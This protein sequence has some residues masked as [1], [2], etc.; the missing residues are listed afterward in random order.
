MVSKVVRWLRRHPV[1][2]G[3][4]LTVT[5]AGLIAAAV[6]ADLGRWPY[7]VGT[8]L[9]VVGLVLVVV[10]LLNRRTPAIAAAL[11]I[12]LGLGGGAWLALNTLPDSHPHW[13]EGSNEGHLAVDSFR[14]GSILFAEGIARDAQTGEVRW[15][16]PDD[17]HVMTT[18]D[19]TVVLD[20]AVEGEEGRR[21]V[22]RLIDSGR[23]VWW[24]MTRGR[25]TAV[26]Q[27]DGVLVISTREGTT[28][29]DLTTGDELW[30]SAR[31]AGTECKQGVPLTLDV[32]D[33]QQS[34]VFLPSSKRG[35]KGVDLAR[36][37]DGEVVA[38]GL[39]C[40]NYG[41]VVA[42]I[43]VEHGDGVLTGRSVSTGALEWEQDWIAQ[44]RPFSLPDSDGTIYIPDKLSRDG[45]GSTVD[46]YS[47][48]DLRTGEITQ[49]RPPGGWVSDTD[50][51]QD[52]RADVLWQPVRRGAS[53]GLWEVG[54]PKVVRIPGSPRISISEADSS[55]W[56]AVDGST[57]NIVGE[58][59][60][61][62][63]A[64]S[65]DGTL[66]G[67]FTGGSAPLDGASTIADGVL[68][69]GA[70]VYPLK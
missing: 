56:V 36:V 42:G 3:A 6:L 5:G 51:V 9:L 66:H 32:P 22:A 37:Y 17:S 13:E 30:T 41:R 27:H 33:L 69:V 49:T 47:A 38:R 59:T 54:T 31:R 39:D 52:Q 60:R 35:S 25:P 44:A 26:A 15:T 18:T 48:L 28:G 34:V 45:K 43:Y 46:H 70:Q 55:G 21:L 10:R 67:P 58:R 65:P 61:T 19:E 1:V 68:R 20:E 62:T 23:Q 2:V 64:V 8:V 29:H 4:T 57:T 50:V 16:A 24:T 63:W 40:L 53:A 14:L 11:A 7:L 12:A